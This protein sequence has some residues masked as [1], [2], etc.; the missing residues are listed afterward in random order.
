MA[1]CSKSPNTFT[2]AVTS[3]VAADVITDA[4]IWSAANPSRYFVTVADTKSMEPFYTSKSVPLCVRYSG[5]HLPNGTAAIFDRGDVKRVLHVISAQN[6]THFYFSGYN[7]HNSDGWFLKSKT[8][9]FVVG[10]LYLP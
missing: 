2:P 6:E 5:Q 4:A 10:Q 9:G 7:N 8:E 3:P 1:G